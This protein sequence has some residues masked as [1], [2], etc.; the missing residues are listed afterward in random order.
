MF[1]DEQVAAG[2]DDSGMSAPE[3]VDPA[4]DLLAELADGGPALE[5]AVGTGRV[6]L[7]LAARGVPV[8]GIDTSPPMLA[9]LRAKPG[10]DAVRATEGD[11]TS[12][13]VPGTFSLVF[14]VFN[15]IMNVTSQDGQVAT[16]GNAAAHLAP[17]GRF[18]VE[19]MVPALQRLPPGETVRVFSLT[20]EHLG[21]DEYDVVTQGLVSHHHPAG[22]TPVRVPFR[23]VW[24]AELDLMARLAG[25]EPEHRWARWDRSPFVAE[26]T[27]HVSVWRRPPG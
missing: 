14:L 12:T 21:V 19:V 15:T 20:P 6:A 9:R 16:F 4:V 8:S 24:P 17:G 22:G 3:V 23:Y 10:A 27:S 13:R 7:P 1:F 18:V 2:Y 11:M 5:F 26:S 25:L